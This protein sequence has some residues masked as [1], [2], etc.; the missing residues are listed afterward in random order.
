MASTKVNALLVEL[1]NPPWM[2]QYWLM[3]GHGFLKHLG[4]GVLMNCR[5]N[6]IGHALDGASQCWGKSCSAMLSQNQF[7]L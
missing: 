7:L 1:D 5:R 3:S 6:N 4:F 2:A